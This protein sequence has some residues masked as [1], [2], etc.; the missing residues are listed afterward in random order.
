MHDNTLTLALVGEATLGEFTRA[1]RH[2]QNLVELLSHELADG[3][4][5]TWMLEDLQYGSAIAT[6]A[7]V[8]SEETPVLKVIGGY[9][10]VGR[11][12]ERR[13]LISF[14]EAVAHEAHKL[15]ELVG[16]DIISL[17][18][19]TATTEATIYGP[20][21]DAHGLKPS[22]LTALGS[23]KGVIQA[24]SSRGRLRFSLYDSL[25]DKQVSCYLQA[26]QE[27]L[28]REMWGKTVEVR[29]LITRE[30]DRGRPTAIREITS[31]EPVEVSERGDYRLAR[32]IFAWVAG[33]E[34]AEVSIR[35]ARDDE[36]A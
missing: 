21:A 33:D 35:R 32:G 18:F 12:L 36:S 27:D 15:T 28:M 7:G 5:I 17:R 31:I 16:G 25:F 8:S 29:G 13:A 30:P 9:A 14:S 19:E 26:G 24:I 22:T 10:E 23:V 1:M 34:P 2:F 6:I 4:E 20:Y 11:A 3:H